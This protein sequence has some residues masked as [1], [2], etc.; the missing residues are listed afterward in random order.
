LADLNWKSTRFASN[1]P[2][3][4][5]RQNFNLKSSKVKLERQTDHTKSGIG[6]RENQN[7]WVDKSMKNQRTASNTLLLD[8]CHYFD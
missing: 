2:N 7:D 4:F 6:K 5:E 8:V 1:A 3:L